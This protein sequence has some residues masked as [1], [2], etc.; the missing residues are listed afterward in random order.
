LGL[1]LAAMIQAI[2]RLRKGVRRDS[3]GWIGIAS[4]ATA[5]DPAGCAV[6]PILPP[7]KAFINVWLAVCPA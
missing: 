4:I 6:R 7:G 5:A 3:P 2:D 1:R